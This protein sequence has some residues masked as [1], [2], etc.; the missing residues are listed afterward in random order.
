MLFCVSISM[1][2]KLDTG[3]M[4]KDG[5]DSEEDKTAY[6]LGLIRNEDTTR[7]RNM[8]AKYPW[9]IQSKVNVFKDTKETASISLFCVAVDLGN[10]S[11]VQTFLDYGYG[12]KDLCNVKIYTTEGVIVSRV[13]V[14]YKF[15]SRNSS[16]NKRWF[17]KS[18]SSS[19]TE[20]EFSY[21]RVDYAQKDVKKS[22]AAYPLDFATGKMFDFLWSKGFRSNNL[23]TK[24]ALLEAKETGKME[25]YNY[26]MA[27]KP[28]T[29]S[30]KPEIIS[31]ELYRQLLNT[32]K[33]NPNSI[34]FE[35]LEK[36]TLYKYTKVE[37][38]RKAEE[39][40]DSMLEAHL[41]KNKVVPSDTLG[42][43][44]MKKIVLG[45]ERALMNVDSYSKAKRYVEIGGT[46]G[47]EHMYAAIDHQDLDMLE[48]LLEN[49]IKPSSEQLDEAIFGRKMEI[50][51]YLVENNIVRFNTNN[52]NTGIRKIR[53]F[54][55]S[56]DRRD[57]KNIVKY[58]IKNGVKSNEE[59]L[60]LAYETNFSDSEIKYLVENM[61]GPIN[62]LELVNKLLISAARLNDS[63]Y[64]KLVL[65]KRKIISLDALRE[66][67]MKEHFDI[68]QY[69]LQTMIPPQDAVKYYF[70]GMQ[71][72]QKSSKDDI[73]II[74]YL[75]ENGAK[76]D[77]S[78]IN[79][80]LGLKENEDN[81]KPFLDMLTE[82]GARPDD[83]A[84]KIIR[85][86][87]G[88]KDKNYIRY[89]IF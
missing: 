46:L 30:D 75:L 68:A 44:D 22:Y 55:Y 12:K 56:H 31:E 17:T 59:S 70:D 78:H 2:Q 76:P 80:I 67:I 83:E 74:K 50:I 71:K 40:L 32:A 38:A 42:F 3:K 36:G 45:K 7:L 43:A 73:E 8:F 10:T 4:Q 37:Q 14:A 21:S 34:A 33:K 23:Y 25:I 35:A 16:F 89:C 62:S 57:V 77:S 86:K 29:L 48:Y 61:K 64:A 11:V 18:S 88:I 63:E 41:N 81:K 20:N 69:F 84:C 79:I 52:L 53:E 15:S 82:Y 65:E 5:L 58:L 85:D 66:A 39:E 9:L 28:E 1:A 54:Y 51:K 72:V 60:N 24:A 13:D 6:V 49:G 87:F 26:I 47:G 19:E 27:N